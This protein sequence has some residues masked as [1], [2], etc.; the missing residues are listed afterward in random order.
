MSSPVPAAAP[1]PIS[2]VVITKNEGDRI[3]RCLDSMRGLCA[4][5]IVV[6]SGSTDDT[7]AV[8]TAHGAR[9]VHQDWLGYAAQ[10]T[11]ANTLAVHDWLLLLD[12]DEWLSPG[13]DATIRTLFADGR[14]ETADAWLLTRRNWFLG[15]RLRGGEPMERL[16]R[17]GWRYL[18]SQVHER[19]DLEGKTV[20]KLDA[21]FEHDTSRSHAEHVTKLSKYATLWAQQRRDAGKRA[22]ALDGPLHAAAY[23]LKQYLL[24]GAVLDGAPGWRFHKAQ[25]AYVLEKYRHLRALS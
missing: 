21:D 23:L 24:R 13:T 12:A 17:A 6:D 20:A 25:A 7:V 16:V 19:P 3:G 10:K 8:A 22:H 15:H 18:P 9:V 5:L 2:G 4:E 14:I 11:F 1:L